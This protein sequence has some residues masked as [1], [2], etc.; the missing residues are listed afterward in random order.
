MLILSNPYY[1]SQSLYY[2]LGTQGDNINRGCVIIMGLRVSAFLQYLHNYALY[3]F[4]IYVIVGVVAIREL[5]Q[6][7]DNA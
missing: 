2:C 3:P 1:T 4:F 6:P 5:Q 7:L